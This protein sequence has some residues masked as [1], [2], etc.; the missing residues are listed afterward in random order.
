M[1]PGAGSLSGKRL[2]PEVEKGEQHDLHSLRQLFLH[3]K[4]G[5]KVVFPE[6]CYLIQQHVNARLVG[7]PF[8]RFAQTR[9][10]LIVFSLPDKNG[11]FCIQSGDVHGP[12]WV[13]LGA[14]P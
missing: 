6:R 14:S 2:K 11:S 9:F 12:L 4:K 8:E 3:R 7:F 13:D 5:S 1:R 10:R